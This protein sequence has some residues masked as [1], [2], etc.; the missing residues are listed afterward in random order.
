MPAEYMLLDSISCAQNRGRS[1]GAHSLSAVGGFIG[2]TF[3]GAALELLGGPAMFMLFAAFI[4]IGTLFFFA[5]AGKL[6]GPRQSVEM[7][8]APTLDHPHLLTLCFAL[9]SRCQIRRRIGKRTRSPGAVGPGFRR[10]RR[11]AK[12]PAATLLSGLSGG[13]RLPREAL[14]L[15]RL[16]SQLILRG[17]QSH[18]RSAAHPSGIGATGMSSVPGSQLR[19]IRHDIR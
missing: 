11:Y 17:Q 12:P 13:E 16:L 19:G 7:L 18:A 14:Q 8:T 15:V 2:P 9:S 3:G 6:P 4:S 10:C 1:F 5:G